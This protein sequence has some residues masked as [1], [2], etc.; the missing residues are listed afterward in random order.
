MTCQLTGMHDLERMDVSRA[1][2]AYIHY[3]LSFHLERKTISSGPV[4]ELY[5]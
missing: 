3:S 5:F 1:F 2:A 4:Y